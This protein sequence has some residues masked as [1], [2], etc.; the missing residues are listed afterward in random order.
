MILYKL[1]F[2]E[3]RK[4]NRDEAED[5]VHS[6]ISVLY[7]NGQ[8]SGEYFLVVQKGKLCA[9]I[10][11]QGVKANLSKFHCKYG[12]ERLKHIVEFFDINPEWELV[13]DDAPKIDITQ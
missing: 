7:H 1:T 10:N 12:T 5:L 9:Y 4:C 13:D 8:A 2:G 3:I 6:Y 11:V